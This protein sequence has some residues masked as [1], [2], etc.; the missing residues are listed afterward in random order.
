MNTEKNQTGEA[1]VASDAQLK[2]MHT[3][4]IEEPISLEAIAS[5]RTALQRTLEGADTSQLTSALRESVKTLPQYKLLEQ[6]LSSVSVQ[7][8]PEALFQT[9]REIRSQPLTKASPV[10]GVLL[11]SMRQG[12]LCCAGRVLLASTF[13]REKGV[14]HS[15]ISTIA[16]EGGHSVL[17]IELD[18]TTSAYCDAENGLYFS[19]PTKALERREGNDIVSLCHLNDF[20]PDEKAV[21]HG[22]SG[23][24]R[25]FMRMDAD[26]GVTYQY[27]S[28]VQAALS[29]NSE[30]AQSDILPDVAAAKAMTMLQREYAGNNTSLIEKFNEELYERG[31]TRQ[32]EKSAEMR[33]LVQDAYE[34]SERNEEQFCM[35]L[36]KMFASHQVLTSLFPYLQHASIEQRR[37][38]AKQMW[39][40]IQAQG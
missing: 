26:A 4:V 32:M 25:T 39:Q 31:I 36:E 14:A 9:L 30:F 7:T 27:L 11:S 8:L 12:S 16:G 24:S 13:L 22:L 38:A 2:V 37:G 29:G 18:A 33:Q 28:N 40:F 17:L 6:R 21:C 23:V 20:I 15:I 5:A 3:S 19:F 1:E 34:T 10:D 35:L